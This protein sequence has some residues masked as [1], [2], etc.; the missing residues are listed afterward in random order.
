VDRRDELTPGRRL[1]MTRST[2]VAGGRVARRLLL[3]TCL[4]LPV[5]VVSA[6]AVV[7]LLLPAYRVA[8]EWLA[9]EFRLLALETGADG[10]HRVLLARVTIADIL[11]V[12]QHAVYPDA[13]GVATA[14][15]P[16]AHALHLPLAAMLI[17]FAL[18]RSTAQAAL[19]AL[20][21][22][23][24]TLPLL[25]F[26]LAAILAANLW[27]LVIDR[28]APGTTPPLLIWAGFLGGGGRWMIGALTGIAAALSLSLTGGVNA[29]FAQEWQQ[30]RDQYVWR[31]FREVVPAGKRPAPNVIRHR[32]PA[33]QRV[34]LATDDTMFPP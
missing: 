23:V 29:A 11:V 1:D 14:S 20:A 6:D 32:S 19:G 5:A 3:A 9:P 30:R 2:P 28:Y 13:R 22:G 10:G 17:A 26:D 27:Q 12:G 7:G 21:A 4:L 34:E 33:S 8:F 16:L 25:P 15:T 24:A 18:P 31:L